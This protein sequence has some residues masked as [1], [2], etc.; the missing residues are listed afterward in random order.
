MDEDEWAVMFTPFVFTCPACDLR[1]EH[2]ELEELEDLAEEVK[3]DESPNDFYAD[4]E[5]D[6]V[7]HRD[8]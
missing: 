8:R 2:E 1:V 7:L 3:L 5:P 4:W 6:E